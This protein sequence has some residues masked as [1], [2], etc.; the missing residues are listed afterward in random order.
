LEI[1]ETQEPPPMPSNLLDIDMDLINSIP[2]PTIVE[3]KETNPI[4]KSQICESKSINTGKSKTK[5]ESKVKSI[6]VPPIKEVK[7]EASKKVESKNEDEDFVVVSSTKK[8]KKR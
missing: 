6:D 4:N 8:N 5:E 1:L 2:N 3:L 7:V